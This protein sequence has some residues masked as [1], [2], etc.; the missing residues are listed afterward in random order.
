[1]KFT[2]EDLVSEY[3]GGSTSKDV[4]SLIEEELPDMNSL[5]ADLLRDVNRIGIKIKR[6]DIKVEGSCIKVSL[7]KRIAE[8]FCADIMNIADTY[9]RI[10]TGI[11]VVVSNN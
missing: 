4:L 8:C 2:A 9:S 6:S 3:L 11:E 10:Y 1:M 5:C 7:D